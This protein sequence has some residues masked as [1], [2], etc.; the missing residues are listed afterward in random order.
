MI[1]KKIIIFVT[2]FYSL[3]AHII[4]EHTNKKFRGIR[5]HLDVKRFHKNIDLFLQ[6]ESYINW[7]DIANK[8]GKDLIIMSSFP[9]NSWILSFW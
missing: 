5:Y 1:L 2:I 7:K 9:D 8:L 6:D 4:Y 3:N